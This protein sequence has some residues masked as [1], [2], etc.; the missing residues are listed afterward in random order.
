[1]DG[2]FSM[3][4]DAAPVAEMADIA[5]RHDA[6]LMTD[7]AHGIGVVGHEGRGSSFM[8]ETKA[9]VPP[10]MGTLSAAR[11]GP[12][13]SPRPATTPPA[14]SP[15]TNWRRVGSNDTLFRLRIG[16]I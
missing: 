6:W 7:D 5:A 14:A 9:D 1:T 10:Q 8:G 11:P 2:I 13:Q 12:G 3:D 15:C 4:G 16:R